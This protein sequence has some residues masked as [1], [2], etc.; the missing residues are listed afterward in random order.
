MLVVD[1]LA[2]LRATLGRALSSDFTVHYASSG[3]EALRVLDQLS[4][5]NAVVSDF[6]L[7]R[8]PHGGNVLERARALFP[9]SVR[10][11]ISGSHDD[12]ISGIVSGG[13]AHAYL[14]KPF[15]PGTLLQVVLALLASLPPS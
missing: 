4:E 12:V 7:G 9:N 2:P 13:N 5:L 8:G 6:D 15:S 10:V 3:P 14:P 11:L 1:D